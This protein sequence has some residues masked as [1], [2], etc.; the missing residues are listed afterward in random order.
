MDTYTRQTLTA[1]VKPETASAFKRRARKM[2]ISASALLKQLAEREV[3]IS[4]GD[5]LQQILQQVTFLSVA[6]DALLDRHPDPSLRPLV[7]KTWRRKAGLDE[8]QDGR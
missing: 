8:V 6:M 3:A 4:S 7:H 5:V 1:Y 2:G